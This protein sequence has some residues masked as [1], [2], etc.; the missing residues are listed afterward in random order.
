M[1]LS[2]NYENYLID[3]IFRNDF[4]PATYRMDTLQLSTGTITDNTDQIIADVQTPPSASG[5]SP[6]TV[7]ASDW[8]VVPSGIGYMA[9][10][11]IAITFGPAT[12][13]WGTVTYFA[14]GESTDFRVGVY[15]ELTPPRS[16]SNGDTPTFPSG[17]LKIT[18]Q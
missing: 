18:I 3:S 7:S 9:Y 11:K 5:Y 2:N 17:Y 12:G 10:N 8:S 4:S 14:L 16:I 6:K 15:G 1:S 13:N